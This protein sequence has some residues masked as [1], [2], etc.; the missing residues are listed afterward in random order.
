MTYLSEANSKQELLE[1]I[2]LLTSKVNRAR[3]HIKDGRDAMA[4]HVLEEQSTNDERNQGA[5]Q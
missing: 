5:R 4:L 2:R 3:I 1:R